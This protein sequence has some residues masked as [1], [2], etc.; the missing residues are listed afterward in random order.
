MYCDCLLVL[1][2]VDGPSL[3]SALWTGSLG[4]PGRLELSRAFAAQN[5]AEPSRKLPSWALGACGRWTF[6]KP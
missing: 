1:F 6:G 5:Q 2:L 4:N 3:L